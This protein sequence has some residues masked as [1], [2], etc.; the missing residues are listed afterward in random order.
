[1]N[2]SRPFPEELPILIGGIYG[3]RVAGNLPPWIGIS[4]PSNMSDWDTSWMLS[5]VEF[6][7]LP[8]T[9]LARQHA[10]WNSVEIQAQ[11]PTWAE[12]RK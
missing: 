1:M 9:A 3:G 4:E 10:G 7:K 5:R 2:H 11:Q 8:E 12:R 6:D